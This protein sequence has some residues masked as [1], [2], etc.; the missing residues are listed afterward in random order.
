M[1]EPGRP[2]VPPLLAGRGR[3]LRVAALV[4]ATGGNLAT[5]CGLA[6]DRPDLVR[7][8][9]AAS[10]RRACPALDLARREGV[11]T[12]PG[13][14]AAECGSYRAAVTEADRE[15]YRERAE[16]FHDR[17]CDRITAYERREGEIDLV[18]LAYHRWIH[19][20]FLA[21]FRDRIVNQHPGDLASLGPDGERSLRGLD[22]V[23]TALRRGD[24]A[25]RTSMFLVD[26]THDGGAVLARGPWV[27]AGA[28]RSDAH[29]HEARQKELSDR[30]VLR[31]CV[32]A[33]AE[34][35][36]AVDRDRRHAD[37][38]PVVLADGVPTPLGGVDLAEQE[39]TAR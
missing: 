18:V 6:R 25:T 32:T 37:G 22:P 29:G 12:W 38:S 21:K 4:S 31:W 39:V 9:L 23:G 3:P 2:A 17:L 36:L 5:L 30:P 15:R 16:A 19:G 28:D 7:V 35:R 34:G 27:A 20:R 24:P 10:D 14:F 33:L 11:E 8:V 26:A 13:D 1:A